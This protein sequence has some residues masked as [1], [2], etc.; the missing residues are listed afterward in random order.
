[1]EPSDTWPLL[2]ALISLLL[3]A[4]FSAMQASLLTLSRSRHRFFPEEEQPAMAFLQQSIEQPDRIQGTLLSANILC[5]MLIAVMLAWFFHV[6]WGVPGAI[7]GVAIAVILVVL[8]GEVL[9]K[10]LASDHPK[11]M[12]TRYHLL[13]RAMLLLFSPLYFLILPVSKGILK[14][15]GV[16]RTISESFP[17]AEEIK[18]LVDASHEE[19]MLENEEKDMIYNVFEFGDSQVDDIMTPRTDVI[20]IDVT[21]PYEEILTLFRAEQFSRM[22]V[23]RETIDDIIGVLYIKDLLL[24]GASADNFS[25]EHIMREPYFTYEFVKSREL[26]KDMREKRVPI[27]IVLDEYGGTSGIVTTEDLVETIVGDINDEYDDE[28][29]DIRELSEGEFLVEGA[30][31]IDDVNEMLGL[32]IVT[33][34]FDSIGGF[35]LGEMGG[36]PEE[37]EE[38]SVGDVTFRIEKIEKNRIEE[39]RITK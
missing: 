24:L 16:E 20:S 35:L 7:G 28:E 30:T 2:L 33:E 38:L 3:S 27:A 1:M 37:G 17:S 8:F 21:T 6:R 14:I 19:G 22:P 31:R 39:L 11:K 18:S 26:F 10:S 13:L 15:F 25:C 23:Y 9:P 4:F 34:E 5:N 36:L 29:E 32:E 12:L